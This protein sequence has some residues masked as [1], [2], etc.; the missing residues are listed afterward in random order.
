VPAIRHRIVTIHGLEIF[1]RQA[2]DPTKPTLV[3]LPGFPSSSRAYIRLIDR[4]ANDWHAVAIDYPGFGSSEPLLESPTFDR[5][6]EITAQVIDALDIGDYAMYMFD[7]GA[8]VGF[9]IA[10][11]HDVRVRGIVT[12]NG[13]A[14]TEG[15]GT[16]FALSGWWADRQAGQATIDAVLTLAGTQSQWNDGARDPEQIDP[17]QAIADQRVLDLPGRADYMK[18]LLWDY[19]NNVAQYGTWQEWLRRRQPALLA[20]W[21]ANDPIFAASGAEAFKRDVPDATVVL[22]DTGHFAIEEDA[23]AIS[24]HVGE[25]M[26]RT[27]P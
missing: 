2:G 8:P 3:L 1:V 18:A 27:F 11:R 22:L 15:F 13:N 4:L 7:F 12:Q 17:E 21:G 6:A 10:L 24:R 23:D 26:A 20:V 19:Q 14:Y 5:L 9:R 16:G 25:L